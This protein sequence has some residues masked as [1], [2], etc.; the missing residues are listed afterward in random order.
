MTQESRD[1]AQIFLWMLPEDQLMVCILDDPYIRVRIGLVG[2]E[3]F[4]NRIRRLLIFRTMNEENRERIIFL[5]H[6]LVWNLLQSGTIQNREQ[7]LHD[8]QCRLTR[9][10]DLVMNV[11]VQRIRLKQERTVQNHRIHFLC[12][13]SGLKRRTGTHGETPDYQFLRTA[14]L[15]ELDGTQQLL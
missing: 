12:N 15:G 9:E 11:V 3:L 2:G 13:Q 4:C 5:F 6:F 1:T 14:L 10:I 7:Q 8:L